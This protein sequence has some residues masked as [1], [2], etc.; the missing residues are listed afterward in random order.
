[1][2]D[3]IR[4]IRIYEFSGPR[5]AVE[6]CVTHAVQGEKTF[7]AWGGEVRVRAA[8]LGTYPEL[9]ERVPDV[10]PPDDDIPF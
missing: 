4:V 6:K 2:I 5:E 10:T 3:I 8:T 9:I 1:M 7:G